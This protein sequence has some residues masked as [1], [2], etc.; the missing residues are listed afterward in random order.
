MNGRWTR[1][2]WLAVAGALA[3]SPTLFADKPANADL[4]Q[5]LQTEF[6]KHG[7]AALLCGVWRGEE[8]VLSLA[9]GDTMTGVPATTAMHFRTGGVTLSSVSYLLLQLVDQGVLKLDDPIGKWLPDLQKSNEV[10]L[11]M[12]ANC[13][14]GYYDYVLS[15][16]FEKDCLDNPFRQWTPQE[17]IAISMAEPMLYQPN[18]G[19][20]Y[21]HTNFVILGEAIQKATGKPL[22]ELL[23][24]NLIKPLGLKGT[25]YITTPEIP[26]P[27]L[28]AFTAERGIYEDAT[29]WNPSWTSH[30]GQMISTLGD[31][32]TLANAIGTGKLL[33]KEG[34]KELTAPTAVGLGMNTENLYYGLGIVCANGW[35]FQNPKFNGYNL[36]FGYL[37]EQKL[38]VVISSIMGPKCA[39][40]TAYAT[41]VFKEVVKTLAPN[42]LLPDVLK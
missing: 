33:S 17:L 15:D 25:K 32:G 30:S 24:K 40:D 4:T 2:E 3:Y 18:K 22:G 6:K 12:L 42:H 29:F 9:L 23:D 31:L 5:L 36:A 7:L 37:P 28:H 8:N 26:S 41:A 20:N 21:S 13:T 38:S 1:R 19:W 16:K 39:P 14:A 34:R 10:T 35:L 11:R 27:V